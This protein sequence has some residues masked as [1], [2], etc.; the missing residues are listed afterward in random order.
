MV[1][2]V[3]FLGKFFVALFLALFGKKMAPLNSKHL[4][5]LVGLVFLC[6]FNKPRLP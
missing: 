4:A 1:W 2:G 3:N 5:T 6:H